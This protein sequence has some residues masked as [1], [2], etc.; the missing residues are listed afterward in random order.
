[1]EVEDF[2]GVCFC[3][4]CVVVALVALGAVFNYLFTY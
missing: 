1:M 3:F 2:I 4:V